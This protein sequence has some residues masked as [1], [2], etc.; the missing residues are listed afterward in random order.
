MLDIMY[1]NSRFMYFNELEKMMYNFDETNTV[2][3]SIWEDL[4]IELLGEK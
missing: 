4:M 1:Q 3:L 2:D